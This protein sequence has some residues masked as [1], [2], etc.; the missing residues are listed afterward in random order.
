VKGANDTIE[1]I[2]EARD[3]EDF[4]SFGNSVPSSRTTTRT[5]R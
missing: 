4:G 5:C 1:K 3:K 2:D